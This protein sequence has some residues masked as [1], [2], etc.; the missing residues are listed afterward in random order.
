M[1][2]VQRLL[3]TAQMR[4]QYPEWLCKEMEAAAEEIMRLRN[5]AAAA[6]SRLRALVEQWRNEGRHLSNPKL[7]CADDLESA[8]NGVGA[9]TQ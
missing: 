7:L 3:D 9:N 4:T 8:I 1:T 2:I 6:D 5:A